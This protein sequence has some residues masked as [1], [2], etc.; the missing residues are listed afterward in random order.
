MSALVNVLDEIKKLL[1]EVE[2]LKANTIP[3]IS[4]LRH[5][6]EALRQELAEIRQENRSMVAGVNFQVAK[7]QVEVSEAL[8]IRT[9]EAPLHLRET[10][11]A[12][13]RARKEE[14]IP[15]DSNDDEPVVE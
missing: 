3:V 8:L 11:T 15:I 12:Q 7:L 13:K 4:K 2:G 1:R 10:K 9:K 5:E 14:A 6:Q